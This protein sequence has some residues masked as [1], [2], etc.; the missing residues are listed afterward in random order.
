MIT[1]QARQEQADKA[2]EDVKAECEAVIRAAAK[3]ERMEALKD[4]H[5]I[6]EDLENVVKIHK[7]QIEGYLGEMVGT[8]FF[9]RLRLIDVVMVHQIR[10]DQIREAINYPKRIVHQAREAREWLD[11]QRQKEKENHAT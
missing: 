5:D 3:Y 2:T 1:E 8:S 6:Q 7:G 4:W 9:K 11:Q 10:M